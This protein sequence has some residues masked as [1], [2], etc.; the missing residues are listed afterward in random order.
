MHFSYHSCQHSEIFPSPD[1]KHLPFKFYTSNR[2]LRVLIHT[3]GNWFRQWTLQNKDF[4]FL[5]V[6]FFFFFMKQLRGFSI[7]AVLRHCLSCL[8]PHSE[9]FTEPHS[10]KERERAILNRAL[11]H[12]KIPI[13]P[14]V[15][16]PSFSFSFFIS[17]SQF[18]THSS[19][20]LN[21]WA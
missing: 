2:R 10:V 9:Y 21:L 1:W 15:F 14:L 11:L 19:S 7:A 6:F 8:G 16:P 18:S 17:A 4:S 20:P 12:P 3:L 5:C 13:R